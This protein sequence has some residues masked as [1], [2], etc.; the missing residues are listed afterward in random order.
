M[1]RNRISE[2]ET[3]ILNTRLMCSATK[4]QLPQC[5]EE[6]RVPLVPGVQD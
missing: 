2:K 4:P 6:W 3:M 1:V 5:I